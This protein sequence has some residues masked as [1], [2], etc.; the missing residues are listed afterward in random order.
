M[1][2]LAIVRRIDSMDLR[3]VT[4]EVHEFFERKLRTSIARKWAFLL[5]L[6]LMVLIGMV[7]LEQIFTAKVV[8]SF[9]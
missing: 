2:E 5:R 8:L 3:C 1:P 9:M 6:E 7:L 4:F